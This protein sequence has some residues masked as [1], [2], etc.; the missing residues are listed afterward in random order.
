M[1]KDAGLSYV[2]VDEPAGDE[3]QRAAARRGH[4]ASAR[5]LAHARPER[6]RVG[7]EGEPRGRALRYLYSEKELKEWVPRII[8]AAEQAKEV[9]V[10]MNNCYGN[11][12]TTNAAELAALVRR[13]Y[14]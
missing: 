10:L 9:H 8:E 1:L 6:R 4:R 3:E 7:E 5:G 13:A 12:G 2:M 11:Y 14:A